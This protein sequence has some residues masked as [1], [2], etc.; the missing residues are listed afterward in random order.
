M[1]AI[2]RRVQYGFKFEHFR[3]K[4]FYRSRRIAGIREFF[5]SR[6]FPNWRF[7]F[8]KGTYCFRFDGCIDPDLVA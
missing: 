7:I 4:S 1:F 6:L 3:V 2:I 8:L 5:R